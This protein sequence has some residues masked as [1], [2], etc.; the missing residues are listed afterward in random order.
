MIESPLNT[1]GQLLARGKRIFT[2]LSHR[3]E[4]IDKG[5]TSQNGSGGEGAR[6][7]AQGIDWNKNS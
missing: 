4:H 5:G 3:G 6:Q 2:R 7:M 1:I